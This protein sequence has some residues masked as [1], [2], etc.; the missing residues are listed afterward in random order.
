M[1]PSVLLRCSPLFFPATRCCHCLYPPLLSSTRPILCHR[2]APPIIPSL[3]LLSPPQVLPSLQQ[4]SY[5][6][7]RRLSYVPLQSTALPNTGL[8][9]GFPLKLLS[10][11][12]FCMRFHLSF[13]ML[14][15]RLYL[16]LSR[17]SMRFISVPSA[18]FSI[19]CPCL[20]LCLLAWFCEPSFGKTRSVFI[21]NSNTGAAS[22]I[23]VH[24]LFVLPCLGRFSMTSVLCFRS[25]R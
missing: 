11:P 24:C 6:S 7:P 20:A 5:M 8:T 19:K 16:S 25:R 14:C 9:V 2:S 23:H 15:I 22:N 4:V 13:S 1:L 3:I 12:L 10:M 18:L 21:R 17:F